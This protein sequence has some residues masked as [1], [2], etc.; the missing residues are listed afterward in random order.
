MYQDTIHTINGSES[1]ANNKMKRRDFINTI[2][3]VTGGVALASMPFTGNAHSFTHA[4]QPTVG[5]II[6]LFIKQVPGA[7]FNNTVDTLKAGNRDTKVTGVVTTMF[8]TVAVIRKAI[9]LGANFIIAHEPTFYNHR[10]EVDWLQE[11]DIYKYKMTLLQDHNIAVWRNHDYIHSLTADGVYAGVLDQ[12]EWKQYKTGNNLLLIPD[13]KLRSLI[14]HVKSKLGIQQLRYI[15]D[16]NQ[17]CPKILLM[18]GAAGGRAQIGAVSKN[19]PDVL[20]CG[21]IQEWETA[22]YVRDARAEGR[23]LALVV[24]GHIASEEPGSIFMANWIKNNIPG[25]T[26]THVTPGNSLSFA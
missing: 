6:D 3:K 15:G 11:D 16:L 13:I 7:P 20:V 4:V 2:S 19:K 14:E 18:P 26:V 9:E 1:I 5:D 21:E 17:T 22:E 10:D 8:A 23:S 24:L 12:L 25:I